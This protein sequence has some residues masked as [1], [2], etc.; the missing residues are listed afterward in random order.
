MTAR[1]PLVAFELL[2]RSPGSGH[3]P[4][5]HNI[6]QFRADPEVA[7]RVRRW[8]QAH[9]VTAHSSDFTI[10]GTAPRK[11]FESLF[12]VRLKPRKA[13]TKSGDWSVEGKIRTPDEIADA[14]EDVILSVRPEI[15]G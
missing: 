10:A 14:V 7:E 15:F 1:T 2:L 13:N 12:G 11:T 8:L 6:D 5:T 9:G 3:T 4:S